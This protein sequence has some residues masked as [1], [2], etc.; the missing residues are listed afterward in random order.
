[1]LTA[2]IAWHNVVQGEFAPIP[3]TI[4]ASIFIAAEDLKPSQSPLLPRPLYHI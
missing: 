1:M 4:L 2:P 3:T